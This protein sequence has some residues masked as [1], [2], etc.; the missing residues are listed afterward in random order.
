LANTP[1]LRHVF[2]K[3]RGAV[4]ADLEL[5][6]YRTLTPAAIVGLILGLF[7]PV[8]FLSPLLVLVPVAGIVC[9][10]FALRKIATSD[11]S[12][13][14]RP[15]AMAGLVLSTICAAAFL[16][17]TIGLK[18]LANRQAIPVAQE[19]F[20]LL[21]EGNPQAAIEMTA[22]PAGRKAVGSNLVDYYA[23]DETAYK[24]LQ[25]FVQTPAIRALLALG[26]KAQVRYYNHL[27]FGRLQGGRWQV[28]QHYAITFP[29]SSEGKPKT[30]FMLLSLQ[31]DPTTATSPGGWR[32]LD[33][34]GGVNPDK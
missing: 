20:Q 9:S 27:G 18:W 31:K 19:W 11:G 2:V 33:Y 32:V 24:R 30:F 14:G 5:V 17:E 10:L 12:V 21:A 1:Q 23:S 7:A 28:A 34:K 13:V 29:D 16:T 4:S 15:A 8:A 6:E 22:D 26:D 25:D 3:E